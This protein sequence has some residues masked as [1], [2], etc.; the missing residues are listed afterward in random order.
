MKTICRAIAALSAAGLAMQA[1]A[2]DGPSVTISGFGTAALTSTD[3]NDA[4]FIR[5]NQAAGVKKDWRTGVDSLLGLQAT[6]KVN[7]TISLTAQGLVRKDAIDHYRGQAAWAFAKFKANDDFSFRVGRMG[8]PIYMI[9][10]F[11]FVGYANTMLR[12]PAEVYRQV[13]LD[14][15]DGVDMLYQHSFDDTSLSVQLG[16]GVSE[17]E[18][19]AQN[20]KFR[21]M[22]LLH[23]VA[24][25][26]PFTLRFGHAQ[27]DVSVEDNPTIAGLINTL[28]ATGFGS[29]ANM[30]PM[31][32]VKGRFTSLGGTMDWKNIVLQAEYA[33]RRTDTLFVHDTNSWYAMAG[34]RMGKI[35]P[36]YYHGSISQKSPRSVGG[37]PTSGPLAAL[38]VG[39]NTLAKAALQSADAIGVRWD[40]YKSMALKAQVDH[41][42]PKDG[43][44]AFIKATPAF[45]GPVNVYAV[46]LDFVF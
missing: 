10:D 2:Q 35:L 34:Y 9:S 28:R 46:A 40:F 20:V 26:G 5:P 25:N 22:L 19:P 16:T 31:T 43:A 24:E 11:R 44:G 30:M 23:V 36:Y 39:V 18:Q 6:M 4:E 14:R 12:P 42:K 3:T 17:S 13:S 1:S 8:A 41:I 7:D 15:F 27:A 37:L 32:D 21:K 45:K 33:Q 38:N 29:I